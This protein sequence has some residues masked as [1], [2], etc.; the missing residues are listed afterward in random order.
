[1]NYIQLEANK[2]RL[3]DCLNDACDLVTNITAR[4]VKAKAQELYKERSF[5]AL[6]FLVKSEVFKAYFS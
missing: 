2:S 5:I 1:M 3:V 4:E 6:P